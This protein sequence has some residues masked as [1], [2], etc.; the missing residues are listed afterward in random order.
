MLDSLITSKTRLKLLI[1][2]FVSASNQGYLRGLAD[3]F[4]ESTNAIRKELNQL[5]EAGY[6]TKKSDKNK[7]F[8]RAN[9]KHSLFKPLQNLIHTFLGIDEIVDHILG[10]AGD[11]QSVSIIGDYAKGLDSGKIEV[12]ILGTDLNQA[13]LLQLA[14]KVALKLKKEI[15]LYFNE[16]QQEAHY[17]NLYTRNLEL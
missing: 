9:T 6:L 7:I 1:K 8:Y 16:P 13:Y 10:K 15:K 4:Q 14:A 2:F 12:L 11:V 3:E 5:E 17:I